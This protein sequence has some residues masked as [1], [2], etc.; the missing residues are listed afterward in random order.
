VHWDLDHGPA[1]RSHP[2]FIVDPGCDVV[3]M[4]G[5]RRDALNLMVPT[6][7]PAERPGRVLA[8]MAGYSEQPRQRGHVVQ[9]SQA[10]VM[11]PPPGG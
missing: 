11:G 8:F 10:I 5:Q 4:V 7:A 9:R 2:A 1:D 3:G 6:F